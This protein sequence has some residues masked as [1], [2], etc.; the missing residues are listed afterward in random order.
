[1]VLFALAKYGLSEVLDLAR[2]SGSAVWVNHG[3]LDIVKLG[4]LRA[5]GLDLTNF[6]HW[7]DPAAAAAVRAAVEAIREHHPNQVLYVERT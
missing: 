6:V 5:E 3:L 2:G 4:E 1:M 7:V